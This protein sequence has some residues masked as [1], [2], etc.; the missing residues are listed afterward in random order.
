MNPPV[1][2]EPPTGCSPV[3]VRGRKPRLDDWRRRVAKRRLPVGSFQ[4]VTNNEMH[5]P[6]EI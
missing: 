3:P 2:T 4:S 6:G 5:P 1:M